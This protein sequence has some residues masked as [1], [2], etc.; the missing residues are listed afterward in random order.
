MNNTI[1]YLL[2]TI[3]AGVSLYNAIYFKKLDE[4]KKEASNTTFNAK[5]YANQFFKNDVESFKAIN[6]SDFLNHINADAQAY[7]ENN[8]HKLG[9]SSD[10]NFIVE[11]N[12]IVLEIEEEYIVVELESDQQRLKI[13]TDFIFG[14]AIREGARR[15]NIGD[16]QNTMD[17]NNIS[18]ELNNIVRE[19]IL[20]P[21]LQEVKVSDRIYFKGAAKVNT[22]RHTNENMKVIPMLLKINN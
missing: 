12:A 20:P 6:A 4:V 3:I 22:K 7:A 21:F 18:V 8:G 11:G 19:Q 10:Y 9:I 2:I 14:N 13:A 5:N 15:A 16:Y 17:F 1:K